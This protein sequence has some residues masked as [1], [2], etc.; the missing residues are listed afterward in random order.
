MEGGADAVDL[1]RRA[2]G[3]LMN[4]VWIAALALQ[5]GAT[6]FTRDTDFAHVPQLPR[7]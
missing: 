2:E 5:H 4:D 3:G 6:L 1:V 7:V